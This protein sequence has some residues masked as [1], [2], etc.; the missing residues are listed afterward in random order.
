MRTDGRTYGHEEA[1]GRSFATRRTRL[2][3]EDTLFQAMKA[4]RG[5]R[6]VATLILNLGAR[7]F[8][9]K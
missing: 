5:I 2:E 9:L 3:R 4:C 8:P 6:G 1:N 7:C